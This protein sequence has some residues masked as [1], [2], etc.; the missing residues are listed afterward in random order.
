MNGELYINGVDAW[1]NYGVAL[2]NESLS[3]LMIPPA[4]KSYVTNESANLNGKIVADAPIALPKVASRDVQVTV[5]LHASSQQQFLTRYNAF[6]SVL[7]GGIVTLRTKYQPTVLYKLTYTSCNQF[8][9]F[10][11]RLAKL[12][13]RFNEPNPTDRNYIADDAD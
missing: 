9:Q 11:G 1:S 8:S 4:L 13:V 3:A 10:N 5:Y 12:V 7:Q 6:V 2:A